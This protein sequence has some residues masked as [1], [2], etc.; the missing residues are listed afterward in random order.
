MCITESLCCNLKH[1]TLLIIILQFLNV[2]KNYFN[3]MV[4]FTSF[5]KNVIATPWI[6]KKDA[7]TTHPKKSSKTNISEKL[8]YKII[9][10]NL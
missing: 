3:K 2:Y 9:Y 10:E 7:H 5:L 1:T 4:E 6:A 8:T